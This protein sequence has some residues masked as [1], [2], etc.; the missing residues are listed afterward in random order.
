MLEAYRKQLKLSVR[1][2]DASQHFIECLAG[3]EDPEHKRKIIGKEFIRVFEAEAKELGD[4]SHLVQ[5]TLYPDVIE[6]ISTKGPSALIKSHHNV[7]GLPERMALTLVEPLRNL[8]KGRSSPR[9][10]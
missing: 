10:I 7:G 9:R 5:G 6:S 4:I 1:G 8:F 2:V 3:V